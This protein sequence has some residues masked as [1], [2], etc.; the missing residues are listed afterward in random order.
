MTWRN[1]IAIDPGSTHCGTATFC[2]GVCIGVEELKP[3]ALFRLLERYDGAGVVYESFSLF[4]W[5]ADAQSFS[6]L[7]TVEVIG[8]I[9][10]ICKQRGLVAVAQRP[11]IKAPTK[12][13]LEAR[14]IKLLSRGH[15]VH[16]KD[17]EVHGWYHLLRNGH[18]L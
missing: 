11:L 10:Y 16:C 18:I 9:K 1:F 6:A 14:G 5:K 8:V 7:R 15:G 3:P 13:Q 4:P 2:D 12:A 17:A